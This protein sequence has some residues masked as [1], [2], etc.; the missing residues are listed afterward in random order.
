[1]RI[2]V[3]CS[4]Q[5]AALKDSFGEP[6]PRMYICDCWGLTV[7][8]VE[9][10]PFRHVDWTHMLVSAARRICIAWTMPWHDVSICPSICHTLLFCQNG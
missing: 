7:N 1:V 4:Q 9:C 8:D 6:S 10:W 3:C 5:M 2:G